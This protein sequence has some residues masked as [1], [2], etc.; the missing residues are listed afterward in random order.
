MKD[1]AWDPLA[2]SEDVETAADVAEREDMGRHK[3][4]EQPSDAE[5]EPGK[6]K[7]T[8]R[9]SSGE[10]GSKPAELPYCFKADCAACAWRGCCV[11]AKEV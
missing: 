8:K 5:Q 6:R 9:A 7:Y 1:D 3:K 10:A 4:T 11:N 2:D